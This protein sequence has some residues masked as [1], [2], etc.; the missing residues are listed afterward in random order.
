M[1]GWS[2]THPCSASDHCCFFP[3]QLFPSTHPQLCRHFPPLWLA[4][5]IFL[6]LATGG[7]SSLTVYV[8]TNEQS[9][10]VSISPLPYGMHSQAFILPLKFLQGLRGK[11]SSTLCSIP[12]G[13]DGPHNY[14]FKELQDLQSVAYC[15][16]NSL[17]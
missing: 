14:L 10:S 11:T 6:F 3:C 1:L 15:A 7:S 12:R 17:L 5:N 9:T 4:G 2:C 16:N 13:D 8:W